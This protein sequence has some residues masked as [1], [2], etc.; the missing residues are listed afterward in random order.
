MALLPGLLSFATS[1]RGTAQLKDWTPAR[2]D[3]GPEIESMT[4]KWSF[5]DRSGQPEQTFF[6]QWYLGRDY[7]YEG[8]RY[9]LADLGR[10]ADRI[11]F[12][13]LVLEAD[14]YADDRKVSTLRFD[15]GA[16]PPHGGP[17][18]PEVNY[19]WSLRK[20]FPRLSASESEIAF[21][22]AY[23]ELKNLRVREATFGGERQLIASLN[24]NKSASANRQAIAMIPLLPKRLLANRL[25]G[26][27]PMQNERRA[28]NPPIGN[29][30]M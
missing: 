26:K 15:M 10:E 28:G 29:L 16:T 30:R 11:S 19:E 5:S 2:G 23:L 8:E 1:H 27:E 17:W 7:Y 20:L 3:N 13:A 9:A 14:L 24:T 22:D 21:S 12:S 18:G 25:L 6:M 4:V